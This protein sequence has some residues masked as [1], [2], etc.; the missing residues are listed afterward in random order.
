MTSSSSRRPH[1]PDWPQWVYESFNARGLAHLEAIYRHL[2]D[3]SGLERASRISACDFASSI[4]AQ[5][6]VDGRDELLRDEIQTTASSR[7][8]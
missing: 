6:R 8:A 4:L 5:V 1:R 7:A 3:E 2:K